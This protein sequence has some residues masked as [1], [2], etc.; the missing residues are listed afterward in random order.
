MLSSRKRRESEK[1]SKGLIR[2]RGEATTSSGDLKPTTT[3]QERKSQV[4][5]RC[6]ELRGMA[7]AQAGAIFAEGDIAHAM[8][9]MVGQSSR[10]PRCTMIC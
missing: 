8:S 9:S 2:M 5:K 7:G 1:E 6:Q 3:M 10:A 4:A